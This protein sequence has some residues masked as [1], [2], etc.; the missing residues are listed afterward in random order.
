[1]PG[2]CT[3]W[4]G[5]DFQAGGYSVPEKILPGEETDPGDRVYQSLGLLENSCCP[6]NRSPS[7]G[8]TA[9]VGISKAAEKLRSG[10][11]VSV[12]VPFR[13][14][15][16]YLDHLLKCLCKQTYP[17]EKMEWLLIDGKSTDGSREIVEK[18]M[19]DHPILLLNNPKR[20]TPD[21]LNL[22][23]QNAR[24]KY[25]IRMDA[26]SGFPEDY[27]EKCIQCL[28]KT[29][30]DNVGG[31]AR[32][33]GEGP[34]G[35][36]IASVLSSPFGVGNAKF[37]TDGKSGYVDTVPFGTFRREIFDKVGLFDTELLRS[38][39]TDLNARIRAAGGKIWLSREIQF[40]YYCRNSVEE[41]IKMALKNGNAL[42]WTI[43]R[44]PKAMQPRHY[45]PFIFFTSLFLFPILGVWLH[46]C[47]Y[48]LLAEL[49]LYFALDVR[50]SFSDGCSDTA[51]RQMW[52]YPLL[53]IC[54]GFGSFLS[55]LGIKVY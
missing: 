5:D 9:A 26:H 31:V 37:R 34:V 8:E 13:N 42:F 51:V 20:H 35:K 44:N 32:T 49:A 45:I 10:V 46:P 39:D 2:L 36:A 38:E 25:I 19:L 1:M 50:F 24:G 33:K 27:I 54:Y 16:K 21:A 53:H 3:H 6:D 41:F 48:F 55:F 17:E 28:E 11:D 40:E 4:P 7:S 14:E 15:E 22:G 47:Q 18:Y 43:R 23:I 29:G 12:V 30:A 52:L